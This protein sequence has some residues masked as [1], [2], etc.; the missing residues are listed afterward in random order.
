MPTINVFYTTGHRYNA[1]GP[2]L[3]TGRDNITSHRGM[4]ISEE[5]WDCFI[6]HLKDTLNHFNV[7]DSEKSDVLAFIETTK[8][9]IV[10]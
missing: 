1:G 10:E 3:Y 9:D 4:G 6:I 5:D 7:P 8:A 2:L